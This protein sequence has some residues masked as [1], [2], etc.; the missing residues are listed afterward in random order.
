MP[1]RILN[2][3]SWIFL[4]V[5]CCCL[6]DLPLRLKRIT[7]RSGWQ[8]QGPRAFAESPEAQR[9]VHNGQPI[10]QCVNQQRARPHDHRCLRCPAHGFSYERTAKALPP[11]R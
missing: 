2:S 8:I 7:D 3:I 11:L 5:A 9:L 6:V 1:K 4:A 10:I